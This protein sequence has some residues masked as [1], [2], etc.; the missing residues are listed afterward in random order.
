L[1]D[2]KA[3]PYL[4][5]IGYRIPEHKNSVQQ[6]WTGLRSKVT[7]SLIRVMQKLQ[8]SKIHEEVAAN[9]HMLLEGVDYDVVLEESQCAAV[10]H[11]WIWHMLELAKAHEAAIKLKE[12]IENNKGP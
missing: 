4:R 2:K 12:E 6:L 7:R 3:D 11:E 10:V 8:C 5:N 9:T 1:Q